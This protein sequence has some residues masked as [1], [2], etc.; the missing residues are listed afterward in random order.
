MKF[1]KHWLQELINIDLTTEKLAE[2][3]TMVGLEVDS[4]KTVADDFHGVVVGEILEVKPH[5]NADKLT[6][7]QV[8]VGAAEPVLNIVCG[9][10]NVRPKL[11]VPVALVGAELPNNFKIKSRTLKQEPG[12]F[13]VSIIRYSKS[14]VRVKLKPYKFRSCTPLSPAQ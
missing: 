7:C 10:K 1:T 14:Y 9:A 13:A 3:L 6:V 8:N 12:F 5:P 4:I 11:K 2:Q